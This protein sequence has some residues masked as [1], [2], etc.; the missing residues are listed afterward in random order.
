MKMTRGRKTVECSRCKKT[1][2]HFGLG[3]CSACLRRTKRETKPEFYLGTCYSEMT[4]RVTRFDPK[5]PRYF[6]KEICRKEE[7]I[8]RF[9][10][11]EEFLRLFKGWQD[12]GFKRRFSPSIDRVDND[13]DYTIDNMMFIIHHENSKK[14]NGKKIKLIKDNEVLIFNTHTEGAKFLKVSPNDFSKYKRLKQ[15]KGWNFEEL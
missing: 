15:C 14:D 10:H 3:M 9:L 4:R 11:D 5:R 6:G 1:K 2:L 12:S 13:K 7:F 8:N